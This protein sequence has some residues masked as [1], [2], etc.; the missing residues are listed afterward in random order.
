MLLSGLCAMSVVICRHLA[1]SA[2]GA[3]DDIDWVEPE[4]VGG[5]AP[6]PPHTRNLCC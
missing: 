4:D 3:D 5:S 1:P 6:A 2:T